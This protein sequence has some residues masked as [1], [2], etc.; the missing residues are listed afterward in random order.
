MRELKAIA[1]VAFGAVAGTVVTEPRSRYRYSILA[2][3][4][5]TRRPSRPPPIV[6]PALVLWLLT[7]V[8]T[9]FPS[10]SK[11]NTVPAV[12]TA[13]TAQ[14]PAA[15]TMRLAGSGTPTPRRT[16]GD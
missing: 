2:V 16:T 15:L 5:P 10:P 3:Q 12:M 9:G 6:Q 4:L 14:P 7:I 8:L 13:P 1:T 11:P